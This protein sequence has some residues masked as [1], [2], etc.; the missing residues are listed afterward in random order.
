MKEKIKI[1]FLA[2]NPVDVDY[3][4]RLDEEAR[5]IDR[6][7]RMGGRRDLFEFNTQFA[8]RP[9]DLQLVLHTYNPNIVH[10]SGH[11]NKSDGIL[12][13]DEYGNMKPVGKE[14]LAHLFELFKDVVRVVILNACYTKWQVKT[15][16]H[17]IDYTIGMNTMV[18]DKEAVAFSASFYQALTFSRSVKEAFALAKNQIELEGLKGFKTPELFI[19]KGVQA[20]EPLIL[21]SAPPPT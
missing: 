8:V 10:F 9:S 1:L 16:S 4:P 18:A 12:L 5:E 3:R 7:I 2:A 19:K 11:A 17:I 21:S 6:R 20:S 13:E 14:A 15:F